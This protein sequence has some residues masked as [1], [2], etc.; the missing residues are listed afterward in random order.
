MVVKVLYF[1]GNM[2]G[3]IGG[4]YYYVYDLVNSLDKNRYEA[5]VGFH[6]D[7]IFVKKLNNNGIKTILVNYPTSFTFNNALLDKVLWP[8]RKIINSFKMLIIPA[9]KYAI[10]LKKNGIKIVHLSNSITGNHIWMLACIITNTKC[11][12][13]ETGFIKNYS[14]T[15]RFFAKRLHSIICVSYA[16][17]N[18]MKKL[19]VNYPNMT[20]VYNGLDVNRCKIVESA[21]SI[22]IKYKIAR[23]DPVIGVIGNIREWKG[24]ETIVRATALLKEKYK[25]IKCLVVGDTAPADYLYLD[26]LKKICKE[27]NID[28]DVIMTGF[29]DYPLD[30]I[31]VMDVFVHTSIDPEPFGIVILEAMFLGKPIISTTIGGP[32]EIIENEISGILIKPRVPELLAA[33]IDKILDNNETARKYGIEGLARLNSTFTMKNNV[34]KIMN[35]YEEAL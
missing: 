4:T 19:G 1:E 10:L 5:L 32:A 14:N 33:A 7:N 16:V 8:I 25:N 20:V 27:Q 31:N 34:E 28:N 23:T 6:W 24:Q 26:K 3:T 2:D 12:T 17:F 15:D 21:E 9:V 18:N 22:K 30:Y 29:Q 35:L 11:M 13:H